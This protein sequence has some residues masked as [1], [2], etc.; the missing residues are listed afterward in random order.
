MRQTTI[1]LPLSFLGLILLTTANLF[2]QDTEVY[3]RIS[4]RVFDEASQAPLVGARVQIQDT[5][6]IMGAITDENGQFV[7]E[8]VPIGR[9]EIQISYIG[10]RTQLK[11]GILINSGQESF[12]EFGLSEQAVEGEAVIIEADQRQVT[13]IAAVVSA[14]SFSVEELRRIPGG[15]DDPARMAVKFPGIAASPNAL[16]NELF[17]RGNSS[18][19]VIWRLEGVDIYNPNHFARIGGTGGAV[20]LFSQQLLANTDFFSGAFPA[21]YGN[22][23]GAVFDARF[24]NGNAEKRQHSAQLSV[25]GL[26]FS[27]EGPFSEK[28]KSSYLVNYRYSTTGIVKEFVDVGAAIPTYQDLSFKLHFPL[29]QGATFNVF[30]I[31]G[32]SVSE[33]NPVLDTA[34]WALEERGDFGNNIQTT[35]GTFGMTYSKPLSSKTFAQTALITTGLRYF[36]DAYYLR[37][38]LIT[39]DSLSQSRDYEYR[40][41]W[42]SFIN[43][44]FGP[45]HTH[46]S[47][48][49]INGL[50]SNVQFI[51]ADNIL[52]DDPGGNLNDTLRIG[53]GESILV[54]AYSRSQFALGPNLKLNVGLHLMYL[55]KSG[56]ASL[57]PRLGLRYQINPQQ[58]LSFGYGLH[59]QMEP[60]YLYIIERRDANGQLNP[61]NENIRFNKA[62]HLV[63]SYRWQVNEALRLGVEL[64]YQAQFN[65]IVGKDL[66]ISRLGGEDFFFETFELDNGGTGRNTGIELALERVFDEGYYFILNGSFFDSRYTPNNGITYPTR[67]NTRLIANGVIGKEW[68]ISKTAKKVSVLNVNLSSS[69]TGP[70]LYTP[71]DIDLIRSAGIFQIDYQNPNSASQDPLV[72]IDASVVYQRNF[73]NRSTQLTFQVRNILNQRPLIFQSY[74][75][76]NDVLI[77][78]FGSGI[79]PVLAWKIQF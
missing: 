22:S 48:I 5:D 71:I 30:G 58:S 72:L 65:L 60:F 77:D 14:R 3:Q 33:I 63:L 59:S 45:R 73:P 74:D 39:R 4:G 78:R 21:D 6:P 50:R 31:G 32:I 26:D 19:S 47:G 28:S 20:T 17:V 10:Y 24:R 42:S 40:L 7:I 25:I 62:H 9:Y 34:A 54:N 75:A 11:S 68:Q 46:R 76:E 36:Q 29:E 53:F 2:A 15:V 56:E 43:H 49:T 8:R 52:E 67:F 61:F 64:Y 44:K 1:I 16:S 23:L 41:A 79:I 37:S 13:N 18:R 70:Q 35:T 69:Y 38:D 57:E 55:A 27:T 66:P 12:L 51:R